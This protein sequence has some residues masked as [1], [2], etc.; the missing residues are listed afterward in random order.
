MEHFPLS[1]TSPYST[2]PKPQP[3]LLP[4]YSSHL[5]PLS[6]YHR[7]SFPPP[8]TLPSLPPLSLSHHSPVLSVY[9]KKLDNTQERERDVEERGG[10]GEGKEGESTG[11]WGREEGG[12]S[13][14]GKGR[15]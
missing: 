13:G 8:L 4:P 5:S 14:Q 12:E 7:R 1:L 3:H 2:S 15:G 11:G 10:G 6:P 9:K